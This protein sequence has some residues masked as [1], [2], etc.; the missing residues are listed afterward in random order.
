M[1]RQ[2]GQAPSQRKECHED[3][4]DNTGMPP[5]FAGT[6]RYMGVDALIEFGICP[7]KPEAKTYFAK[8]QKDGP[9]SVEN[10]H[11][12]AEQPEGAWAEYTRQ[13]NLGIIQLSDHHR[14]LC[15]LKHVPA[16]EVIEPIGWKQA[17]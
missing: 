4:V 5:S 16:S 2:E 13:L 15:M 12:E 10:T 7:T 1:S 9:L 3:I 8:K 17:I 11:F 6:L 14:Y